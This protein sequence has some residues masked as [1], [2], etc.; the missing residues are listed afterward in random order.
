[1]ATFFFNMHG[2]K[3]RMKKRMKTARS[4]LATEDYNDFIAALHRGTIEA[5]A[6]RINQEY[7]GIISSFHSLPLKRKKGTYPFG[8]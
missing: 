3:F 4:F 8:L 1:M 5:I 2:M 6:V 7:T